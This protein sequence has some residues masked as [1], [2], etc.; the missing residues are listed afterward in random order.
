MNLNKENKDK[1]VCPCDGGGCRVILNTD[2]IW[3]LDCTDP[4]A[5]V[6]AI[7]CPECDWRAEQTIKFS[8]FISTEDQN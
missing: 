8:D 3:T 4:E 7:Q 5:I 6:I 2:D 1:M